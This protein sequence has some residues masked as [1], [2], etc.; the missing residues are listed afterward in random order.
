MI[1]LTLDIEPPRPSEKILIDAISSRS[2][3][4]RSPILATSVGRGQLA[5]FLAE[6]YP[7]LKVFA[8]FMDLY[9]TKRARAAHTS[10]SNLEIVCLPDLP[11]ENW[12]CVAI[13]I[14]FNGDNELT[15]DILQYAYAA[16]SVGGEFWTATDNPDDKWLLENL[17][18]FSKSIQTNKS[19]EGVVYRIL[20]KTPLRKLR[21]LD[22]D[23][24]FRDNKPQ[25]VS[26]PEN[27]AAADES[28]A[29]L[30]RGSEN[31]VFVHSRPGTFSHRHI[32]GGA[33]ALL[34]KIEV[35]PG[36][37]ILDLGCGSGA[38]SLALAKRDRS[39]LVTG[40]DSHSRAIQA[41][42]IG[43]EKNELKNV[44]AILDD[45]GELIPSNA[46]DVCVAN[47]PYYSDNRIAEIFVA[48]ATRALRSRGK[49]WIVTKDAGWYQEE[50]PVWYNDLSVTEHRGYSVIS[51]SRSDRP[52]ASS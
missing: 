30:T 49:L 23:Y 12:G 9:H 16:L 19:P 34:E 47:P 52:Y 45:T 39:N 2:N 1:D 44:T 38:M 28:Q 43:A 15:R 6:R 37:R 36:S 48:T 25:D 3:A 46:F 33:R 5:A 26:V 7:D 41:L 32:D 50:L 35:A 21:N 4:W 29:N 8:H 42:Q 24:A 20:K 11:K 14:R 10:L 27:F 17:K 31:L 22:C 13:P 51:G 18:E 40:V